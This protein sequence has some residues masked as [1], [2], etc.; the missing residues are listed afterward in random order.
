MN[1][2]YCGSSLPES[3][4]EDGE[5][6]FPKNVYGFWRSYDVCSECMKYFGDNID[7]LSINN[8]HVLRAIEHLK[9]TKLEDY[10]R[11]FKYQGEDVY[12]G[13]TVEMIRKNGIYQTKTINNEDKYF[14]CPEDKWELIG[15]KWIEKHT[16]HKVSKGV[17]VKEIEKLRSEY[18]N[19]KPGQTIK[20]DILEYTIRKTQVKHVK[21]DQKSFKSITPLLAK[22]AVAFIHYFTP[23]KIR[24]S[25]KQLE[26]LKQHARYNVS[27]PKYF[28][29]PC[30]L[31]D[32]EYYEKNHA[33]SIHIEPYLLILDITFFGSIN[34][35]ILLN[36]FEKCDFDE[37][38]GVKYND[39]MFIQDFRDQ[40]FRQKIIMIKPVND[41]KY[42]QYE[43]Q[44]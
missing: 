43:I 7:N 9:L 12:N 28:I 2:I 16:K 37:V 17:L 33:V 11:N 5:H 19:I 4:S 13:R 18:K 8:P 15:T 40:N 34:W 29:N 1:C 14:E 24:S 3:I 32:E 42:I 38:E 44:A 30:S 41:S 23:Q 21:P 31:S 25:I 20:S 26:L 35:R 6:I 27:I 22:I 36:T 39:M 10:L